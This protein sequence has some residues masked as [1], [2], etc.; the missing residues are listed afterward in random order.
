MIIL[1]AIG[2]L[3]VLLILTIIY[4]FIHYGSFEEIEVKTGPPPVNMNGKTIAYKLN[5]GPYKE[6]GHLFTEI[7]GDLVRTN[8][9]ISSK[10]YLIGFYY[11]NPNTTEDQSRCRYAA[12]LILPDV[13]EEPTSRP[14]K[15]ASRPEKSASRPEKSASRPEE[16]TSRPEE[17]TS[18]PECGDNIFVTGEEREQLQ[19]GLRERGYE[20]ITL[21]SIDHVVHATFPF[22]GSFSIVIATRRVYPCL[23]WY[24]QEHNLCAH[25]SIEVYTSDSIHF[26]LPLS[27]QDSFYF[28]PPES[29]DDDSVDGSLDDSVDDEDEN[30]SNSE[31][32][33][34]EMEDEGT[35]SR[36]QGSSGDS[37]ERKPS[38]D[39]SSS[40][41][42]IEFPRKK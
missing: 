42:E 5:R 11:D 34:E 14:E 36:D 39:G 33:H 31:A 2:V 19:L 3:L 27:K 20:F 26:I 30:V 23:N 1:I 13:S 6:S 21:P 28:F 25:P 16:S 18:R 15:S 17:P 24:V 9:A 7:T 10:I 38:T 22:R 8:P 32:D 41:E 35:N 40:F 29:V 37:V 12:G 4:A